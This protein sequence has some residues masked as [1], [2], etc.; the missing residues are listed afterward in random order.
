MTYPRSAIAALVAG[1]IALANA[2]GPAHTQPFPSRPIKIVVPYPAGGPTDVLARLVAQRMAPLIGAS[3][4]VEDR[5][6]GAAGSVGAKTVASADPDGYTLL[7]A[8]VGTLTISPAIY[9]DPEREWTRLFAPVAL[10]AVSAQLLVVTSGL[11]VNSV[12][13]LLAF[14][15][16][17]PGKVN[18][19]SAGVGS[20]PHVLGEL[21][22]LVGD[23]NI[24]HIPY[25]GSAPAITDLLAGQIQM[26]FDTSVVLL[27][28]IEAG[29]LRALAITSETRSPQLPNVP[30]MAELGMPRLQTMLWSGLLAPAGTPAPLVAK[31]NAALNEAL[32]S[33]EAKQSLQ[34]LGAEPKAMSA[35]EFAAFMDAET[36]R[37]ATV[38]AEAGIKPE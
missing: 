5:P 21:L 2:V 10:V 12:P 22:R 19:A 3:V 4:I 15:R 9:K 33:A 27:P 23:V 16:A 28:H 17:N 8:Q 25:R 37:W 32:G 11:P 24:V 18:F 13:E 6:G 31:L 20:Q 30:T 34:K 7:I 35:A 38:V 14:A 1:A 26:M 36:R 29:K